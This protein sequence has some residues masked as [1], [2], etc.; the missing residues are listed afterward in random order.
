MGNP[1]TDASK[2]ITTVV[3]FLYG[4]P[5][6]LLSFCDNASAVGAAQPMPSLDVRVPPNILALQQDS[7]EVLLRLDQ[8]DLPSTHTTFLSLFSTGRPFPKIYSRI[9]EVLTSPDG[10]AVTRY[11]FAGFV[12]LAHAN[13]QGFEGQVRLTITPLTKIENDVRLG[14]PI[15][16]TCL[17]KFGDADCGFPLELS[18]QFGTLGFSPAG[19]RL[20]DYIVQITGLTVPFLPGTADQDPFYFSLGSVRFDGLAIKIRGWSLQE[21]TLFRLASLPP[22][23]WGGKQVKVFPGCLRDKSAC[24]RHGRQESFRGLGV[25]IPAFDPFSQVPSR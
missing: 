7:A 3:E 13:P 18:G 22:P 8:E 9:S 14:L 24:V 2:S 12:D 1:I 25:A 17:N 16:A 11:L 21:P 20:G 6:K 15:D 19:G 10:T 4:T 5:E 23:Y